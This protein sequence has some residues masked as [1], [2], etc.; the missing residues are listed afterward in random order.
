MS[1]PHRKIILRKFGILKYFLY[2]CNE[3]STQLSAK[4][5]G[6]ESPPDPKYRVENNRSLKY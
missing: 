6:G 1:E 5:R 4:N 2:L 3:R